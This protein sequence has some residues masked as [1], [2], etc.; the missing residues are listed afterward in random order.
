MNKEQVGTFCFIISNALTRHNDECDKD[1]DEICIF[2]IL[3]QY[4]IFGEIMEFT[5]TL[6]KDK[7]KPNEE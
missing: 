6:K 5:E 3:K 1:F 7:W 4:N 2:G